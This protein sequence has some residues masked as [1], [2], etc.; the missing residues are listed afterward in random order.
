MEFTISPN[1]QTVFNQLENSNNAIM[2]CK[3]I[4]DMETPTS[5][6][7]KLHNKLEPCFLLE[8]V[9]GGENRGRYSILGLYPDKL[10][11]CIDGIAFQAYYQDNKTI[12]EFE[13]ID[14]A[15]LE[16]LQSQIDEIQMIIP[17]ELPG[18]SAG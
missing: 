11:Q 15:P 9:H 12:S 13:K 2:W 1:K 14:E 6:M 7:Q 3:I 16:S 5:A 10:W 8:S 4:A 17:P 18:L